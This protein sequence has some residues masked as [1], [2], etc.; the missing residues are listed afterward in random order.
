M[1]T[2]TRRRCFATGAL[3]ALGCELLGC[4]LAEVP[5]NGATTDASLCSA[6][7]VCPDAA[8]SEPLDGSASSEPPSGTVSVSDASVGSGSASNV[9]LGSAV[10][11]QGS[12]PTS[13]SSGPPP[14]SDA[15]TD[16]SSAD[17][18]VV[19]SDAGDAGL[20]AG[21]V[22]LGDAGAEDGAPPSSPSAVDSAVPAAS[23]SVTSPIP[24]PEHQHAA[25]FD[26][27]NDYF[28]A[29]EPERFNVGSSDFTVAC[30]YNQAVGVVHGAFFG[31]GNAAAHTGDPEPKPYPGY[32][33]GLR[34]GK[35][36]LIVSD[37]AQSFGVEVLSPEPDAWH[38]LVGVRQANSLK[39]YLDGQLVPDQTVLPEGFSIVTDVPVIAGAGFSFWPDNF[40]KGGLDGLAFYT[41]ALAD[42]EVA[43]L[44]ESGP[45]LSDPAL[46]GYW[47]FDDGTTRDATPN[48]LGSVVAGS[49][50]FQ[51][52]PAPWDAVPA[53]THASMRLNGE[54]DYLQVQ[55]D[56]ALDVGTA[57]FTLASWSYTAEEQAPDSYQGAFISKGRPTRW[58]PS[59][60]HYPGYYL[61]LLGVV[62]RARV[63]FNVDDS[64]VWRSLNILAPKPGTWYHTAG[65]R[66][67]TELELY[68]NGRLASRAAL[69]AA[70]DI[71]ADGEPLFIGASHASV[72]TQLFTGQLDEVAFYR[73]ALT[74]A[75]VHRLAVF[76]PDLDDSALAGFWSFEDADDI[77][78]NTIVDSLTA[79]RIGDPVR[80]VAPR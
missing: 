72:P 27:V 22:S 5:G 36:S 38:H 9:A 66:R 52:V 11:P 80:V 3:L 26:G 64:D 78:K 17:T 33:L 45:R 42:E 43:A 76:G 12:A 25:W 58:D 31:K 16:A 19:T 29:F 57:D 51:A 8:V 49:P 28:E 73:R 14:V 1:D 67:G 21:D 63:A 4:E 34:Y 50:V 48:D 2:P 69:P 20:D 32:V 56:D 18:S 15:E 13:A 41:R 74:R 37:G 71:Q 30:W 6:S 68:V 44:R 23:L 24:D 10:L 77:A 79:Q 46:H 65:V 62:E 39:L 70:M 35:L 60:S 59:I 55:G 75:E 7:S 54:A 47:P 40:L 53:V 61:G